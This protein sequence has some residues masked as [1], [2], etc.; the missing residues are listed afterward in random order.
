[1]EKIQIL[2][3]DDHILVRE[4]TRELLEREAD[5]EVVAEAGDGEEAVRLAAETRPDVALLD[6]AMPKLNGIEATRQIK[7]LLPS[8]AILILTAYDDD[9][10]V[11]ALLEAGAAGYLLKNVRGRDLVEAVR[12]VHAGESVLHPVIA[13]KVISRFSQPSQSTAQAPEAPLLSDR[14]LEVLDLAAK[15]MSNREIGRALSLST[16]TIQAH[17]STIFAK[18]DVGSRTEA[19]V[20]A[21]REGWLRLEDTL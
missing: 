2:L 20:Y 13:R 4:G 18:M 1:M 12:Q 15:G 21:L 10:Y 5:L 16:R 11:F 7:E 17:L 8:T 6:I 14:E 9:Q 3:A 19:V